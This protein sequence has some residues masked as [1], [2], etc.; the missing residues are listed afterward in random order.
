MGG[1][2]EPVADSYENGFIIYTDSGHMAVHLVR[3]DR[4]LYAGDQPTAEEA[5]AAC[6]PTSATSA[7]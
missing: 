3:P 4:A 1:E 7:R 2:P 5:Q 6:A